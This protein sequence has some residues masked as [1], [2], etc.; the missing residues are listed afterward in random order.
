MFLIILVL[1]CLTKIQKFTTTWKKAIDL[2]ILLVVVALARFRAGI[3]LALVCL[4]SA[5]E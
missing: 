5:Y 3:S 1:L 4:Q 2:D